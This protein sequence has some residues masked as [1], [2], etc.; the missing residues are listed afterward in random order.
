MDIIKDVSV[1]MFEVAD[2]N[3]QTVKSSFFFFK[4]AECHIDVLGI[5]E[6]DNSHFVQIKWCSKLF[7]SQKINIRNESYFCKYCHNGFGTQELFNEH[8]DKGCTEVEG[9]QIEM[10][11]TDE[12]LNL[13]ITLRS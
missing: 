9:Q 4:N 10:P 12:K 1:D 7:N 13:N 11:T 5:D 3:E 2:G 8:Y 6:D